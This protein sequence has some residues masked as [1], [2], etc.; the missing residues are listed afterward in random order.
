MIISRRD[1]AYPYRGSCYARA[2]HAIAVNVGRRGR[3]VGT[4][5][6]IVTRR[7]RLGWV[8]RLCVRDVRGAA[9]EEIL[10]A[11]IKA[12]NIIIVVGRTNER[13]RFIVFGHKNTDRHTRFDRERFRTRKVKF[14]IRVLCS[15]AASIGG[16]PNIF[17]ATLKENTTARRRRRDITNGA[18]QNTNRLKRNTKCNDVPSTQGQWARPSL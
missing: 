11:A 13:D 5:L 14:R 3:A 18:V 8:T 9:S 4:W 10:T 16:V 6:R 12:S 7:Y 2:V 15:T 17:H 1:R